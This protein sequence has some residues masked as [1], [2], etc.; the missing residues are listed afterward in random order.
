MS[1]GHLVRGAWMDMSIR[2]S[3]LDQ[4]GKYKQRMGLRGMRSCML[5]CVLLQLHSVVCLSG[6]DWFSKSIDLI[7]ISRFKV[8]D[9]ALNFF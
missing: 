5:F 4:H 3:E 8:F 7:D 6:L 9:C 2:Y 1:G